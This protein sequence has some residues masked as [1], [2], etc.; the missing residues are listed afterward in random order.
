M[1]VVQTALE[2]WATDHAG[3]YPNAD[4]AWD[5]PEEGIGPYFP[6]GDIYGIGGE[7]KPGNFPTNPY[8][9]K[10]YNMGDYTDL[11]YE[12]FYGEFE[13]G[14][15][16]QIRGD[17]DN[18]PYL[19]WEGVPEVAGSIFIGTYINEATEVA[20]EYGMAGWGRDATFVPMYE[21]DPEADDP[22]SEEYWIFFVLHN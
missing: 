1:H 22:M 11:N 6:G 4:V 16:A 10:R 5:T 9:T 12:D 18:C 7:V 20:E 13:P 21:L 8:T 3:N 14:Q 2:A 17:D 15:N 19:D